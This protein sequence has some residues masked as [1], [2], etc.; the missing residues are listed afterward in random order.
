MDKTKIF[1]NDLFAAAAKTLGQPV[2][3]PEIRPCENNY[4]ADIYDDYVEDSLPQNVM[5]DFERHL[6]GC[7]HCQLMLKQAFIRDDKVERSFL[8]SEIGRKRSLNATLN[9][10]SELRKEE[11]VARKRQ[12]AMLL[13]ASEDY[14]GLTGTAYGL[15]VDRDSSGGAKLEC[16]AWVGS[17]DTVEPI[18]DLRG[19][20]IQSV[21]KDN[22]K[23]SVEPPLDRLEDELEGLFGVNSLLKKLGL[24]RREITVDIRHP[25]EDGFIKE[26]HSLGLAVLVSILNALAGNKELA[27]L[28]FSAGIHKN[29]RLT[30]VGDL[31]QKIAIAR[32]AGVSELVVSK[33]H[34]KDVKGALGDDQ[35]LNIRFFSSLKDVMDYLG[36]FEKLERHFT[37]GAPPA[38]PIPVAS[39]G[40]A[41][42]RAVE[43]VEECRFVLT[44]AGP[45]GLDAVLAREICGLAEDLCVIRHEMRPV[46]TALV[47]GDPSKIE[48]ILP[49]SPIKL[50][51]GWDLFSSQ[52][53]LIKL[54]SIV[55]GYTMGFVADTC[56][57]IHS[58]RKLNIDLTGNFPVNRLL[59]GISRRYAILS[60]MT[61][62]LMFLMSSAD[63]TAR[64][65]TEGTLLGRYKNGKWVATDLDQ[66]EKLLRD[67]AT[68]KGILPEVVEKIGR[69]AIRMSDLNAGGLFVLFRDL[70]DMEDRYSNLLNGLSVSLAV[71][72]I[73]ELTDE[74]LVNFAKEDGAVLIDRSGNI[75]SFMAFLRPGNAFMFESDPSKGAR[76]NVAKIVSK[77]IGCLCIVNSQDGGITA[78]EDGEQVFIL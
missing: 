36:L 6:D 42:F 27:H 55:D 2:S 10:L 76:H 39:I 34:E 78:Y 3:Q 40:K 44:A 19:P 59:T 7:L 32:E 25:A 38:P 67:S 68:R 29:G 45:K 9:Q 49:P 64:V 46:S 61:D 54:S 33:D 51:Q 20:E 16:F 69:V 66:F 30:R 75:H 1:M 41:Y 31:P 14:E 15:A 26:A 71:E 21:K 47:V 35:S 13:A 17:P 50:Q 8:M 70:T 58:V 11:K 28:A 57:R 18:L 23:Y 48:N 52:K 5:A 43:Q 74:E 24:N 60:K 37:K 22:T 65:F 77:E 12:K 4:T 62:S 72:S 73:R 53:T 56:G 63:N